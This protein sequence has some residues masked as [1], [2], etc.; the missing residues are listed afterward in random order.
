MQTKHLINLNQSK[1][2]I[3]YYSY[4]KRIQ[5]FENSVHLCFYKNKEDKRFVYKK[6]PE[7]K[8]RD[9]HNFENN[10]NY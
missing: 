7:C 3:Y 8:E 5:F 10:S 6:L 1:R 4:F 9:L 2:K